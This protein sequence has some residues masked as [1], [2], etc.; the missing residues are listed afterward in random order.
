MSNISQAKYQCF[1]KAGEAFL[2]KIVFGTDQLLYGDGQLQIDHRLGSYYGQSSPKRSVLNG[3]GTE[4]KSFVMLR[5]YFTTAIRHLIK[6]R[7]T[8]TL[9][10]NVCKILLAVLLFPFG[11]AR[12]GRVI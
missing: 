3:V 12:A 7:N 8:A 10:L 1:K 6:H 11:C 9:C 2:L 5:N 4:L